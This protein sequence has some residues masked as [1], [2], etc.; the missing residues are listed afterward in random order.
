MK[1]LHLSD[2]ALSGAPIRLSRLLHEYSGHASRHIVWIP[3][4]QWRSF[5]NDLVGCEMTDDQLE[6]WLNWAD[7]YHFHNRW[8]RQEIFKR[9]PFK[10]RKKPSVIQIHSPRE[11]EDFFEELASGV[12]LAPVAQYHPRQWPEKRFV[13]PNVVD[14]RSA[15]YQT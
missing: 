5:D 6:Y 15:R 7:V 14:V 9:V 1:I 2:T 13:V 10:H 8:Q 4:F 3:T 12:P 11:S